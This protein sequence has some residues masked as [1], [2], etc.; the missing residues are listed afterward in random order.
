[1]VAAFGLAEQIL[2]HSLL[3][4]IVDIRQN[5][6][7]KTLRNV[8]TSV[9]FIARESF[10][11]EM[12]LV[13]WLIN[14]CNPLI[15]FGSVTLHV[16]L[17]YHFSLVLLLRICSFYFRDCHL[18][19]WYKSWYS[20]ADIKQKAPFIFLSSLTNILEFLWETTLTL[21]CRYAARCNSFHGGRMKVDLILCSSL[22]HHVYILIM[23]LTFIDIPYCSYHRRPWLKT[24]FVGLL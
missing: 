24:C 23:E 15:L 1:M 4:Q 19:C 6:I 21:N 7:Y 3:Y 10:S 14:I 18:V 5:S 9:S 17:F 22:V 8:H 11:E 13:W 12:C 2:T 20:R 16:D